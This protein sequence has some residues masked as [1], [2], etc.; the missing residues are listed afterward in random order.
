MTNKLKSTNKIDMN[1]LKQDLTVTAVESSRAESNQ[2]SQFYKVNVDCWENILDF[3]GL[4]DIVAMSKT[5]KRM[6]QVCGYYFHE[7]FAE[8]RCMLTHDTLYV[9]YP[10]K[11]EAENLSEF[12]SK[13]VLWFGV[14]RYLDVA[15]FCRLKSLFL[16]RVHLDDEQ[17]DYIKDVLTDIESLHFYKCSS[18]YD[19]IFERLLKYCP[20]LKRL[21]IIEHDDPTQVKSLIFHQQNYPSLESFKCTGM[22][23]FEG[24]PNKFLERNTN[25]KHLE[26]DAHILWVNK[27]AF[28]ES[29]VRLHCLEINYWADTEIDID[30]FV[31]P[32]AFVRLLQ[33]LHDQSFYKTLR[34]HLDLEDA[35]DDISH[36]NSQLLMNEMA[37][38]NN[39]EV[40]GIFSDIKLSRMAHLRELCLVKVVLN[41]M[42][43]MAAHLVNLQT[44]CIY[45]ASTD[46][47]FPFFKH[48]KRLNSVTVIELV[49]P[50]F[51][52]DVL[53][54]YALNKERI[55]LGA[56]QRV[57]V[58]LK[59]NIYLATK[60]KK[61]NLNLSHVELV[62]VE[63]FSIGHSAE[64]YYQNFMI[65]YNRN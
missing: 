44:L 5:C 29:N 52:D 25:M 14:Q 22:S 23:D 21:A 18:W 7:H 30:P 63:G 27:Q 11:F 35:E 53:N 31:P 39:L 33:S 50:L 55:N 60:K 1:E 43:D 54:L 28:I 62:R 15:S 10:E 6:R 48:S 45:K 49:G 20:K 57:I 41:N 16:S 34:V 58:S 36:R 2:S 3:L 46:D 17:I 8:T 32:V 42:E 37:A 9:G 51:K 26:V 64:K 24:F 13:L 47:I 59:G 38:L 40:M 56:K 19:N 4:E 61:M 65:I 12:M